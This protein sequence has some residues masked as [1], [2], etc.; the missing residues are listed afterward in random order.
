MIDK[1]GSRST[2]GGKCTAE[3]NR[4][5]DFIFTVRFSYSIVSDASVVVLICGELSIFSLL[6]SHYSTNHIMYTMSYMH[7]QVDRHTYQPTP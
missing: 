3:K 7:E 5:W 2:L 6:F 1:R 4:V